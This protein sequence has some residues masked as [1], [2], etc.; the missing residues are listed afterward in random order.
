[1]KIIDISFETST[2]W[3]AILDTMKTIPSPISIFEAFAH[4]APIVSLRGL[5]VARD[6]YLELLQELNIRIGHLG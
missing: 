1:V 5:K 3:G 6:Y 2:L 4:M